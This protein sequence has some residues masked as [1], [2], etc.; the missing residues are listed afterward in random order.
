MVIKIMS[1][2]ITH[3]SDVGGVDLNLEAPEAAKAAAEAMLV[4]VAK[5]C[6]E[7]QARRLPGSG[8]GPPSARL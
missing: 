1:P 6:A 8:N 7:G 4:K 2:D 3:K 5:N